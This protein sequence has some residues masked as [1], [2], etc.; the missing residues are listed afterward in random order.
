MCGIFGYV[1]D[2]AEAPQLV[3]AGLKKLE[4]RGYDSWG[5]AARPDAGQSARLL[6]EKHTGKIGQATTGLPA[7]RAALGHTRWATHGGVTEANAHPHLDCQGRLAVIH[8]GIIE[9]HA[10]LRRE[11]IAAGHR[12]E[13]QTD[14]EVVCHL[15]ED[16]LRRDAPS[17]S[18]TAPDQCERLAQVLITVFRRL[19]GLS[20]IGVL[21]PQLDCIVAAKN[22]SPLVLGWGDDGN[23]LA[24]DSSALLDH[25]RKLTFLEDG[26]AALLTRDSL[27]STTSPAAA[28][29]TSRASGTSPGSKRRTASTATRTTWPKKSPSSRRSYAAL[30][31]SAPT[32]P[33]VWPTLSSARTI[34]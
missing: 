34:P 12:F 11:L 23:F 21:E 26:Q 31:A 32:L 27:T 30:L 3:L 6:V 9:N 33:S 10:E 4:Y 18:A 2:R 1:G 17:G 24:S 28:P 14:T 15:L 29:S 22:G 16:E 19:D 7:A 13:S 25:T 20:A 8:N 5:I